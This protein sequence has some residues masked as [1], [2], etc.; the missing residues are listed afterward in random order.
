MYLFTQL[1]EAESCLCPIIPKYTPIPSRRTHNFTTSVDNQVCV[2]V[3][4]D[5]HLKS[6]FS[7]DRERTFGCEI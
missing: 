5:P 1:E 2:S 6:A 7:S 4:L 3:A